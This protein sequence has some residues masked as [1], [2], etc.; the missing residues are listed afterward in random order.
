MW[1][2]FSEVALI[3]KLMGTSEKNLR[4]SSI[5]NFIC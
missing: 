4:A 5:N 1:N 2:I 3:V